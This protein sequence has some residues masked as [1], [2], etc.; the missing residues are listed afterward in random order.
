MYENLKPLTFNVISDIH[1]YSKSCGTTG[2]DFEKAN[3]KSQCELK[4]AQE[5]L[6]ALM[7]Q[8]KKD[9]ETDIVLVSGDI[10]SNAEPQSHKEAI[11]MLASL[12]ESGK[13][14]YV[15]TAT[16]DFRQ[17][18]KTKRYT[19]TGSEEIDCV[20]RDELFDMYRRFGPDEAIA[21]HRESMSYVVQLAPG[22]RL[23]ALNDDSNNAGASGFSDE[24]FEWITEQI[25]D[26]QE[27]GQ[28]IIPMT[29]HPLISPSPFYK[30]IGGSNMMGGHE[31]RRE[32]LADMGVP[33][34]LTGHTHMQDISYVY[35]KKGNIFYDITTAAP[36]GYPGT[37][38]KITADPAERVIHVD[39][40][41]I[42]EQPN[43]KMNGK[44]V[45]DHLADKFFGM[46]LRLV[47][48][49]ATDTEKLAHMVTSFSVNPRLIYRFG[50]IIKPFAKLFRRLKISTA[51]KMCRK[52]TGLKKADYADIG[53]E[54]VVDFIISLVTNLYGG[55]SPYSPD[56]AY[57]KIALGI[58]A[59]LDSILSTL[60]IKLSKLIKNATSIGA[61]V[62]PLLFNSGIPDAK[63][64]LTL[65]QLY[66]IT[67]PAP[68]PLEQPK[69]DVNIKKSR[70]GPGI[71]IGAVLLI[72]IF[73]PLILLWL[74]FGFIINEIHFH[75]KLKKEK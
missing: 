17:S 1:Y 29:H 56:T 49:A 60:G 36:V 2:P 33:F 74:I 30:I 44:T 22:Y 21:V 5:I 19:E 11:E 24:C 72:I 23:F 25:K 20:S 3:G 64:D 31:Q 9:T 51:A 55:D 42:T 40:V 59:I 34:I 26:A 6:E 66:D 43:F 48:A 71:I 67:N 15:I 13:R 39:A 12:Q 4:N 53:N 7:R 73:L 62:E 18:G 61:L 50:W 32:Q 28:F 65:Y 16:H 10:T 47:D 14:V 58:C 27:N 46:I 54:K 45:R 69:L 70:K 75:S 52:E 38:R 37:Y 35:S 57:Y 68:K 8:L 63:A 41:E